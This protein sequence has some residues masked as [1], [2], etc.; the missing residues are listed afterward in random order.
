MKKFLNFLI[1]CILVLAIIFC[2]VWYLFIYDREFTRDMLL[3]GAR[4]FES[5]GNLQIS[6]WLYNQAYHR[7]EDNDA[8]AIELA[9][10]YKYSGNYTQ[11]EYT[12]SSAIADG[13]G[14]DLYI[15]LCKTYVEQD[16]LLDAVNM[17]N[18]VTDPIIKTQLDKR[19]PDT[20]VPS[21]EPGFYSQHIQLDFSSENA[22]LYISTG[23]EFPSIH[24]RQYSPFRG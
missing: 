2:L 21:T 18:N 14:L 20:P 15:A 13:G 24:P 17:L 22:R 6:S 9:D 23:S 5:E 1:P 3:Q 16:K 7:A 10:Q 4:Y 19:R 12:L 11:A 8:V